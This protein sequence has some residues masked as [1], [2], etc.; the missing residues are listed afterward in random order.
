M[1]FETKIFLLLFIWP[2]GQAD[3]DP[4]WTI[5]Q[6]MTVEEC[7]SQ[8]LELKSKMLTEHGSDARIEHQCFSA[9]NLILK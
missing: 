6:Y 3:N 7:Q 4:L 8:V 9:E 2:I 1:V 5:G